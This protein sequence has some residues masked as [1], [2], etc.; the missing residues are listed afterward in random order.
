MTDITHN[1]WTCVTEDDQ[2]DDG[3]YKYSH[4]AVKDG[5]RVYLHTSPFLRSFTPTQERFAYLVDHGFPRAAKGN[6]YGYEIDELIEKEKASAE[7]KN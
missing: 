3:F 6:W 7:T 1:G 2:D 4:Y 5:K